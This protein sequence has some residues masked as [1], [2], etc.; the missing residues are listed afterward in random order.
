M[1]E[2][3]SVES[4]NEDVILETMDLALAGPEHEDWFTEMVKSA[5]VEDNQG[6]EVKKP[7]P[8]KPK[9]SPGALLRSVLPARRAVHDK[10]AALLTSLNRIGASPGRS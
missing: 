10:L 5:K 2:S 6:Q 8:R 3:S 9:F 7:N 4:S 1:S